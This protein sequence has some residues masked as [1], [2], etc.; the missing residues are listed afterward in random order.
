MIWLFLCLLFILL[1]ANVSLGRS[2]L[3]P[4]TI[5]T[6]VWL[7]AMAVLAAW[8][9]LFYAVSFETLSLYWVG[10]VMFSIGGMASLANSRPVAPN[11]V[12]SQLYRQRLKPILNF[13]LIVV[14]LALPFYILRAT[15]EISLLDPLYFVTRR[16]IDIDADKSYNPLGNFVVMAK[17]VAMAIYLERGDAQK[18]QPTVIAAVLVAIIYSILEGAKM[19]AVMIILTLMFISFIRSGRVDWGVLMRISALLIGFFVLGLMVV[20]FA[21]EDT[22]DTALL[23]QTTIGYWVGP[24]VAFNSVVQEPTSIEAAHKLS[25]FFVETANSLGAGIPVTSIHAQFA[26]ISPVIEGIN[27][28]TL[29]FAYF[30]EYSW[31]GV[32]C[33][34]IILGYVLTS[35]YVRA[36]RKSPIAM[37]I[38]G[39]CMTGLILCTHGEQFWLSLNPYCKALIFFYFVYSILPRLR[40]YAR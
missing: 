1:I 16:A 4:P 30:R 11:F 13:S 21:Y 19:G 28:Y 14:V 36:Q 10:A 20:N 5:F 7:L 34:M 18:V 12:P 29:Y 27:T 22:V 23:L 6:S 33:G 31:P 9:D 15:E 17:F 40:M 32:I 35:V 25:R 3:Y 26:N 8:R 39:M 38:Y 2:F 24:L 37:L